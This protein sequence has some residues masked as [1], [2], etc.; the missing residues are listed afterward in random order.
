MSILRP[1][2]AGVGLIA[3]LFLGTVLLLLTSGGSA[4]TVD[5]PAPDK[6][7]ACVS[8]SSAAAEAVGFTSGLAQAGAAQVE[9]DVAGTFQWF[10]LDAPPAIV[11]RVADDPH[12]AMRQRNFGHFAAFT[13]SKF[14]RFK[15]RMGS[16]PVRLTAVAIARLGAKAGGQGYTDFAYSGRVV[17]HAPWRRELQM[18]GKGAINCDGTLRI[19]SMGIIGGS[20]PWPR[21]AGV[22]K[23]RRVVARVAGTRVCWQ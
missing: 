16:L 13:P 18:V 2:T 21:Q 8:P 20:T 9:A 17:G 15:V 11:P 22:C 14:I 12:F 5:A 10:S 7:S 6:E 4:G 3:I 1:R 19:W 23:E